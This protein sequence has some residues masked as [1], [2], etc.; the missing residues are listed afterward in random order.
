MLS[1]CCDNDYVVEIETKQISLKGRT[2]RSKQQLSLKASQ[3]QFLKISNVAVADAEELGLTTLD[4]YVA[5]RLEKPIRIVFM[6]L[7]SALREDE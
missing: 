3:T 4:A 1:N 5:S 6:V 7:Q 2:T